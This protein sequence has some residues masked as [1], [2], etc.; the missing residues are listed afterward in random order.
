MNSND[1][2]N[3]YELMNAITSIRYFS[4]R[5]S[6]GSTE[7]YWINRNTVLGFIFS[8]PPECIVSINYGKWEHK[9]GDEWSCSVCGNVIHTE[10]SR[11]K[12]TDKYCSECGARM[13]IDNDD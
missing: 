2:I 10:S 3:A 6:D 7:N 11:E 12:P 13:E 8:A 9:G 1:F 4:T 5:W